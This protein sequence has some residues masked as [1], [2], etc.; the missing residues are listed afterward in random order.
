[1]VVTLLVT[2]AFVTAC[3]SATRPPST[4]IAPPDL[5]TLGAP[6]PAERGTGAA[7]GDGGTARPAL[8]GGWWKPGVSREQKRA[9]LEACFQFAEAQVA[10][11]IRIDDDISAARD[12]VNSYQTRFG[13]LTRRVD[14]HY[15]SRQRSALLEDCMQSKGYSRG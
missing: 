14:G 7:R 8:S 2:A 9:D 15:Y 1:M 11:D 13:G 10:N 12:R 3:A 6:V 5:S 4:D